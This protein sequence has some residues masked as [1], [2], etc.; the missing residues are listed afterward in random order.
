M[1]P[2][3]SGKDETGIN[4]SLADASSSEDEIGAGLEQILT[5][6]RVSFEALFWSLKRERGSD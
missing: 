2:K 6:R 4:R 1:T 3:L 5:K